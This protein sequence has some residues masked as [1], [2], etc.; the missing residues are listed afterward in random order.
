MCSMPSRVQAASGPP[1]P[2]ANGGKSR[3]NWI[4]RPSRQCNAPVAVGAVGG[5]FLAQ[6]VAEAV[7]PGAGRTASI[8]RARV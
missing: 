8:S 1:G 4:G 5:P 7:N 3:F 2:V 6:E